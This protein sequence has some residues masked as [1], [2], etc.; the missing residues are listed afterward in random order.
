MA[1]AQLVAAH[2][3]NSWGSSLKDDLAAIGSATAAFC[4]LGNQSG[5]GSSRSLRCPENQRAN[6]QNYFYKADHFLDRF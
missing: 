3:L 1:N 5:F 6:C 2:L 4:L